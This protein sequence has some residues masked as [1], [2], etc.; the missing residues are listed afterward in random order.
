MVGVPCRKSAKGIPASARRPAE[1]LGRGRLVAQALAATL[2]AAPAVAQPTLR[3][4]IETRLA[5]ALSAGPDAASGDVLAS[6]TIGTDV[7][8]ATFRR[9]DGSTFGIE[10]RHPSAACDPCLAGRE[11][12]VAWSPDAPDVRAAAQRVRDRLDAAPLDAW[13]AER[14][15]GAVPARE[16]AEH[17]GAARL[18]IERSVLSVAWVALAVLLALLAWSL[19]RTADPRAR[20]GLLALAAGALVLRWLL[21]TG[22]PGDVTFNLLMPRYGQ[23][24]AALLD[25]L[26]PIPVSSPA[27]AMAVALVLGSLA[28]VALVGFGLSAGA[29]RVVAFGAGVLLAIQPYLV[30]VSGEL[31]R[32]PHV[33]FLGIVALW[34]LASHSTTG[35][36]RDL[37]VHAVATVLCIHSRPEGVFAAG[38][39]VLL[40]AWR[41]PPAGRR[42]PAVASH[43]AVLAVA[44]A[45][46]LADAD[47]VFGANA[48]FVTGGDWAWP[49]PFV[50]LWLSP[51][52]VSPVAI[53]AF[54]AGIAL[55]AIRR[56]RLAG[57]GATGAVALAFATTRFPVG[58]LHLASARYQTLSLV[59]FCWVAAFA[60]ERAAGLAASR[61]GRR[62]GLGVAVAAWAAIVATTVA[63]MERVT[64]PRTLDRELAFLRS[65]VPAIPPGA[66]VL[67]TNPDGGRE[68]SLRGLDDLTAFLGAPGIQWRRW[69]PTVPST[70]RPRLFYLQPSCYDLDAP[71]GGPAAGGEATADGGL[72]PECAEALALCGS[73]PVVEADIPA[74]RSSQESYSR[75][76][77]R[78]GLYRMDVPKL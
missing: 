75:P 29:S 60:V 23:A 7:A 34:G 36:L 69:E 16:A 35:R 6:L 20:A 46:V 74:G 44:S 65:A 56:D 2:L 52:Y 32:Q 62:G 21:A 18:E 13:T 33:L 17:R 77:L 49:S 53:A 37:A 47:G 50:T 43:V 48:A 41:L 71:A 59:A 15:A 58:D 54:V 26:S 30:R 40:T 45:R 73:N 70:P 8:T 24:P 51:E 64:A 38:L 55:A 72:R 78:I 1:R 66:E 22:G 68:S 63:P 31:E 61:F 57:W 9:G 28:P 10:L 14:P 3:V 25:L 42:L 4:G 12:R 39:G 5:A 76:V 11:F 27:V 19:A 67:V